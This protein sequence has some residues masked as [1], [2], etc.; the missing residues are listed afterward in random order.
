MRTLMAG[1]FIPLDT[2]AGQLIAVCWAIFIVVWFVAAFFT[3]RTVERLNSVWRLIW[4]LA[5]VALVFGA[6]AG[7]GGAYLWGL[8]PPVLNVTWPHTATIGVIAAAITVVGLLITLWARY[9]LGSNWS[10]T[11]TFKENHELI[12]SGPYAFARHPIYT[13]L[14]VM[15][16]GTVMISGHAFAFVLLLLGTVVLWLKA[17]D[18]ERMMTKHFPDAYPPYKRRVKALIPFVL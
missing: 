14:I 15:L 8:L 13:G 6:T 4:I 9:T 5:A 18:E 10:G 17:R 3:K 16:L 11:V 12:T 2:A 1:N 7:R